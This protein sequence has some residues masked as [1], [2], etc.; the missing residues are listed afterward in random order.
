MGGLI[1]TLVAVAIIW[2][3]GL[4]APSSVTLDAFR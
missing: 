1:A 3:N 2:L 4:R